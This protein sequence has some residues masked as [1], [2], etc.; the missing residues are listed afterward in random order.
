MHIC[1]HYSILNVR[2]YTYTWILNVAWLVVVEVVH[3][4]RNLKKKLLDANDDKDSW[5]HRRLTLDA[6]GTDTWRNT[7]G[8]AQV[9]QTVGTDRWNIQW[10]SLFLN[11]LFALLIL[12]HNGLR[13]VSI[14][15]VKTHTTGAY[16]GHHYVTCRFRDKSQTIL[17]KQY[18]H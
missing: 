7:S 8:T 12:N 16:S 13:V 15:E 6:G 11:G 5:W 4:L 9:T 2:Q 10:R 17:R 1:S 18:D 14:F 3:Y